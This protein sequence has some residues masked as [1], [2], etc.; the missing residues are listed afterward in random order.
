MESDLA[1]FYLG[2]RIQGTTHSGVPVSFYMTLVWLCAINQLPRYLL[3]TSYIF[4]F[5]MTLVWLYVINQL[6]RYLLITSYIFTFYMTLVWLY[7]YIRH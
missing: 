3:I 7:A 2:P 6:P 1:S 4:T 5:Y